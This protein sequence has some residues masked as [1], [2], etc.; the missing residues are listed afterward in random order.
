MTWFYYRKRRRSSVTKHYLEYKEAARTLV[1]DRLQY[2]NEHY[3]LRYNRVAIRN[4]RRCWGSCTSLGNLNFSYKLLFL[5]PHLQDYI[6]VHELCHLRELN[7]GDAFWSLV[8]ETIPDHEERRVHLR[9]IEGQT[10]KYLLA[11]ARSKEY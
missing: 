5:P 7:H 3:G 4:Q 6:I 2:F 9:T 11:A 1:H 8:A 10:M